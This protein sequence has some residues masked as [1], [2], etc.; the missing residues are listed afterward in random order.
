M[1][2]AK[3]FVRQRKRKKQVIANNLFY[4]L[5][6]IAEEERLELEK[7]Y[8]TKMEA[9]PLDLLTKVASV[10]HGHTWTKIVKYSTQQLVD[11]VNEDISKH[12]PSLKA[13]FDKLKDLT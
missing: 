5:I 12:C 10:I 13:I 3:N 7:D 1:K 11:K 4:L 6:F 2:L 8:V 9:V